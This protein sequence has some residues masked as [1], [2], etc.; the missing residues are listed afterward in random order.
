MLEFLVPVSGSVWEGLRGMAL[1][2][3]VCHW[4]QALRF[5]KIPTISGVCISLYLLI[6]SQNV[7]TQLLL[8][9]HVCL[10]PCSLTQ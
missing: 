10:L 7:S 3:D 2:E 5:K 9:H 8:Q 6:I 1:Q 4:G